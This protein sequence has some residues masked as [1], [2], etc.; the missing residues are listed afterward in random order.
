MK[1][2][3]SFSNFFFLVYLC[4]HMLFDY[5]FLSWFCCP[6]TVVQYVVGSR[7]KLIKKGN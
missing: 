2:P 1:S 6:A 5:F 4:L 3:P 7:L